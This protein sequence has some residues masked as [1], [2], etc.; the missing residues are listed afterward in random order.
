MASCSVQDIVS[1]AGCFNNCLTAQQ[2]DAGLTFL[3]CVAAGGIA[4]EE[5]VFVIGGEGGGIIGPEGGG[6]IGVE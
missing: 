2:S 4:P 1:A 6:M 3:M 5:D